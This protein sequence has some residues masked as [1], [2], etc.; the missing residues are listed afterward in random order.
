MKK[1]LLLSLVFGYFAAFAQIQ[2]PIISITPPSCA[3]NGMATITNYSPNFTY[4]FTPN[5]GGI[6][7]SSTGQIW[8]LLP[9]LGYTVV[10][11]VG[12]TTSTP[13]NVFSVFPQLPVPPVPNISTISAS[14]N[15][16]GSASITNYDP[17]IQYTIA[18]AG[19][20]INPNTFEISGVIF[21]IIYTLTA[22]NSVGCPSSTT[23]TIA[24]QLPSPA[25][26]I[27]NVVGATCAI[28]GMPQIMNYNSN[29]TYTFSP[30]GPI[31]TTSGW[32]NNLV[33]LQN[34]TV[35]A[36]NGNC[37]SSPSPAFYSGPLV[38]PETPIINISTPSCQSSGVV[39]TNFSTN[40]QYVITP[41]GPSVAN[42]VIFGLTVGVNYTMVATNGSCSSMA[43][44]PF[45][46]TTEIQTTPPMPMIVVTPPTCCADGIAVVANYNQLISYT[47]SPE[48]PLVNANGLITG[49]ICGTVYMVTASNGSCPSGPV[50]FVVGCA[51]PAPATPQVCVGNNQAVITNYSP[52]N[53]YIFTPAANVQ[54]GPNGIIYGLM[55][56]TN[57]TI[58]A[59]NGTSNSLPSNV[60]NLSVPNN[61]NAA[62]LIAFYDSNN[63]G[64][65][66]P[67]ELPFDYGMFNFTINGGAIQNGYGSNG[68]YL[69]FDSNPANIYALSYSIYSNY[70]A[71]Y[72]CST[73]YSNININGS[74]TYYFPITALNPNHQDLSVSLLAYDSPRAGFNYFTTVRYSNNSPNVVP[75]GTITF[76]KDAAVSMV[77]TTPSSTI[78]ATGFVYTFTNLMPF[79]TRYINVTMYTPPL[80]TVQIN[81][82]ITHTV[83]IAPTA[84][85]ANLANNTFSITQYVIAAYDPNDKMEA[86]GNKVLFATYNPN[87]EFTYTI[88]FE[89]EGNASA[90]GVRVTDQLNAKID[91]T[92]VR[93]VAASHD[94]Q[95]RREGNLLTWRFD[96]I[97]LPVSVPGTMIGHGFI[98]FSVKMKPGI[99][100]WDVVPNKASI[101]FDTNPAIITN[102]FETEFYEPLS[103][104][105]YSENVSIYPN[106]TNNIINIQAKST[107]ESIVLFDM[108]GKNLMTIENIQNMASQMSLDQ[109]SAGVYFLQIKTAEG[110]STH[111]IIKK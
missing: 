108:Q 3:S 42:G 65:K 78:N 23:F 103:T 32:I 17:N 14:C 101:F 11:T 16:N 2:A 9:N 51:I 86:R 13:S 75:S 7:V 84:N 19:P 94:Y 98:T 6:Q 41:A 4:V 111:K 18:P 20:T 37:V 73:A 74:N 50:T 30:S 5:T 72:Q 71:F 66:D 27:V 40:L 34:Y 80:P 60:F 100:L 25:V 109:I 54:I 77:S 93:M 61:C 63:N 55:A 96:N 104:T 83:N 36:S 24:P 88:R 95:L 33:N 62:T 68:T 106:P 10:A 39:I 89:N 107:L 90:L 82:A 79:E 15:S 85:D 44:N 52:N 57:Y 43:S 47:F 70:Q 99:Q 12:G 26:P 97:N 87:D 59:T 110:E 91:E 28:G 38:Q 46:I 1:L 31:V 8:G 48:G 69:I 102:E 53:Q 81:Q 56:N 22:T 35:T 29:L 76:N 58:V 64:I 21:G 49:A 67:S 45:S 92:T 105:N